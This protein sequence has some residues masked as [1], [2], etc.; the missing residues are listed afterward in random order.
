[1]E[2]IWKKTVNKILENE[3]EIDEQCLAD[4]CIIGRTV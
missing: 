4:V 3:Q 2:S 1:M